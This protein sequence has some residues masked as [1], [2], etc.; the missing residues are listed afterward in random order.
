[1]ITVSSWAGVEVTSDKQ[2]HTHRVEI[3]MHKLS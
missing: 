3:L 1:M 2:W